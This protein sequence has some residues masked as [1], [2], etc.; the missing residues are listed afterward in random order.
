LA[1]E[2]AVAVQTAN[3]SMSWAATTAISADGLIRKDAGMVGR[4]IK[5]NK[6]GRPGPF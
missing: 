1:D 6:P 2:L 3:D 5:A 4:M